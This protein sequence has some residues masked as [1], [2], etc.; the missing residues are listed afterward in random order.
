MLHQATKVGRRL[1]RSGSLS[2]ESSDS[3]E[4]V[5]GRMRSII[6]QVRK[7]FC[8][9]VHISIK[10]HVT[11]SFKHTSHDQGTNL[12]PS[13]TANLPVILLAEILRDYMC[14]FVCS[15]WTVGESLGT[16]LTYTLEHV[17][18]H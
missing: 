3:E 17:V 12:R 14:T 15:I 13:N 8:V 16:C 11:W 7:R 4:E 6:V 2:S 18:Y 1:V 9:C 5:G 10:G